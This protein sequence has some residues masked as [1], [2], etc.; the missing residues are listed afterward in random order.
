MTEKHLAGNFLFTVEAFRLTKHGGIKLTL[1]ISEDQAASALALAI[2]P[3]AVFEA[4]IFVRPNEVI[5]KS[6]E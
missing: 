2:Q 6:C 5:G 4:D 3:N 1:N